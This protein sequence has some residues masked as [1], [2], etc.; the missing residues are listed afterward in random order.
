M[1]IGKGQISSKEQCIRTTFRIMPI[2]DPHPFR[3]TDSHKCAGI[4]SSYME[5]HNSM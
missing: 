4:G 1:A 3:A 5:I 2:P